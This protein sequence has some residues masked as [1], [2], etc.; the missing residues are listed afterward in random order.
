VVHGRRRWSERALFGALALV[1]AC[2]GQDGAPAEAAP[3]PW[4]IVPYPS[5][6]PSDDE[7]GKARIELGRLLFYDP[8][9]SVDRETACATCHS[10]IW[11]MGDGIAVGVGHGAGRGAGPRREGPN[12]SRRNSLP[13]Y[14][15]AYRTSFLWD[16]RAATLE[17]QALMPIDDENELG[18]SAE[19]VVGALSDVPEYVERFANAFPEDPAISKEHLAAALAAFERTILANRATYDAYAEGRHELMDADEIEGMFRF[20]E[21]GC[22]TCHV[23]PLFESETFAD[24]SVPETDGVVD[25]G[26]EEHT[27]RL[28]D[29][30][31]FRTTTLRNLAATGPYFHNGS[32]NEMS[33]A[34]R[35]EMVQSGLPFDDEDVERVRL[36][37]HNTLRDESSHPVRPISVP[38]GLP[39]PIDPAGPT[40]R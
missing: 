13:L 27:G 15:L 22:H 26:L 5:L 32:V 4:P 6:P 34:I 1:C 3:T 14:N 2:G 12:V 39:M 30:G 17:Q 28:E 20:A 10:E 25:R 7:V 24:R 38:S 19:D 33:A 31:K 37:I 16:G 29:R 36:F 35:H 9:L 23:P 21:L 18:A 40:S 11:G 8:I